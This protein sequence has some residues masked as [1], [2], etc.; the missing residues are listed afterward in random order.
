MPHHSQSLRVLASSLAALSFAAQAHITLETPRAEAGKSYKAVLR[1]GHGC[2]GSPIRELIVTIPAGVRGA[3]PMLK[4][5]WR[6]DIERRHLEQPYQ[7]H[8]RSVTEDVSQLRYSGG[9]LPE[10]FYDEFIIVGTLPAQPGTLYWK[11]SQVCETGR[12]DWDQVPTSGQ[13]PKELKSPAAVLEVVPGEHAGHV[14]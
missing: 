7:S 8:G 4:P 3:K 1:A 12:I 10:G 13:S 11:V 2:E 9:T 6:V 14:H 5:G